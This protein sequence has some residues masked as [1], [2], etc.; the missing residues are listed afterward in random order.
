MIIG[1][2]SVGLN[3]VAQRTSLHCR[4]LIGGCATYQKLAIVWSLFVQKQSNYCKKIINPFITRQKGPTAAN[5]RCARLN[6]KINNDSSSPSE[7][8]NI[9]GEVSH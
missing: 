3:A 5:K 4:L 8:D 2:V 7:E 9:L 1:K 6:L